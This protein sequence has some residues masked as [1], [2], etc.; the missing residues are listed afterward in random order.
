MKENTLPETAKTSKQNSRAR[1]RRQVR[2][3]AY[4]PIIGV[5]IGALSIAIAIVAL[6]MHVL[7]IHGTAMN[8][9]L[10]KGDVVLTINSSEFNH[11]DITTFYYNNSILIRRVIATGGETIDISPDG[12]V[13]VNGNLVDEPYVSEKSIGNTEI[14]LPYEVSEKYLFLMADERISSADSR[15]VSIG[16]VENSQIVGKIIFRI[17]PLQRFGPIN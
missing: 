8:P 10:I 2:K 12:S 15:N 1:Y 9:T 14:G 5:I 7:K 17:W 3:W 16:S 4:L 11:G 6:N 13:F